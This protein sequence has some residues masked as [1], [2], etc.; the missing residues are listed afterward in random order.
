MFVTKLHESNC[1]LEKTWKVMSLAVDIYVI[2]YFKL[3][4]VSEG[5]FNFKQW[6]KGNYNLSI[7]TLSCPF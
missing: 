3:G 4:T 2:E 1:I 6:E 5:R 7:I